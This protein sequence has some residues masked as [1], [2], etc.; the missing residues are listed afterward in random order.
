MIE[1]S[2]VLLKPDA[3]KRG[4][5]GKILTRFED[6]GFKIVGAKMTWID[7]DFGKRHY[8]DI[9]ERRGEKVLKVLLNFMTQGPVMALCVEGINAVENIRKI[10]GGTE[11][12]SAL[13]GTIRG[14]F[15][16]I[17]FAYADK[18]NKAIENLIHASGN[19]EEAK[20]E[21]ALWFK[22]SELHSYKTAYE[23]HTF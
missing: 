22:E 17:S 7:K 18:E 23:T 20:V 15:A 13:P 3:V 14:D 21:V 19:V 8:A 1:R 2:L 12:K 11:P 4:L 5:M 9:A 10:V 16:H 6:A